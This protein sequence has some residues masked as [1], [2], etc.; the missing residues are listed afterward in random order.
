MGHLSRSLTLGLALTAG[1]T[2]YLFARRGVANLYL[3]NKALAVAALCLLSV[4][5]VARASATRRAW[6]RAALGLTGVHVLLSTLALSHKFE[7]PA[8]FLDHWVSV[9]L[10]AAALGLFV[11]LAL[12]RVAPR[13][14]P[15]AFAFAVTHMATLKWTGWMKWAGTWEPWLPPL[16]LLCALVAAAALGRWARARL[17]AR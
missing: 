14:A 13:W 11:T 7:C 15:L 2:A 17:R 6:G 16:S 3:V 4:A 12:R 5:L 10:G 1:G 9:C 8:W